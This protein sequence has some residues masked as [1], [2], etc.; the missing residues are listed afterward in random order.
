MIREP[1]E[2][3]ID[4]ALAHLQTAQKLL[5]REI[6]DYPGPIA[7]CDVQFNQ[8]LSDRTRLSQAIEALRDA[9][10]IPTPRILERGAISESR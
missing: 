7:G 9:P 5:L 10:F 6:A 2:I 8:L 4:A 1:Y 3:E